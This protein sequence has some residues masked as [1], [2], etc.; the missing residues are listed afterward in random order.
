MSRFAA[1]AIL[2]SASLSFAQDGTA[3]GGKWSG[4]TAN[5]TPMPR[6]LQ[7]V[8]NLNKDRRGEFTCA[9][10]GSVPLSCG[11]VSFDGTRLTFTA[12]GAGLGTAV[13]ISFVGTLSDGRNSIQGWLADKRLILQREARPRA[14]KPSPD[15]DAAPSAAI[16]AEPAELLSRALEKIKGTQ[17]R[18]L[19]Y[20]CLETLERTYYS[21]PGRKAA[22]LSCDGVD[23]KDPAHLTLNSNDRLRLDVAVAEGK[24]VDS[25]PA[26]GRFDSRSVNDLVKEGPKSTGAF[27]TVLVDIFENPGA[28]FSFVSKRSEHAR[29]VFLYSFDVPVAAS[30]YLVHAG[31]A[32]KPTGYH[33]TFEIDSQTADLARVSLQTAQLTSDTNMCHLR[34]VNDYH[35]LQ[36][37][38]GQFL[39]PGKSEQDIVAPNATQTHSVTT[40]SACHEFTAQS[41]LSF[42]SDVPAASGATHPKAVAQPL[43]EGLSLMLALLDP[44]DLTS[45]AA[46]DVV[47]ARVTK[48]VRS[49]GS[50]QVLV[51]AG[52]VVHGRI[53][54][55]RHEFHP[56]VFQ[57]SIHFDTLEQNGAI[58]PI[59]IRAVE[60]N[61][62]A[63]E[64]SQNWFGFPA[65]TGGYVVPQGFESKWITESK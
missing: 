31:Q 47:T 49:P 3:V 36:V 50:N 30:H 26:T 61:V 58:L 5:P 40:F 55:L 13:G 65:S 27:G 11:S 54:E 20:T 9:I 22:D 33:G 24:E 37:G 39:I 52:A 60:Q 17:L 44:I 7:V 34:T 14:A 23:F 10:T 46:G 48:A 6:P 32:W 15:L 45:A 56:A 35:Y 4:S 29:D 59:A 18:L 16:T 1:V 62:T 2:F 8:V 63:G 12:R 28:K 41:S 57:L 19:K 25:W 42:D 64:D 21:L 38:T 51:A 43:P 53:L